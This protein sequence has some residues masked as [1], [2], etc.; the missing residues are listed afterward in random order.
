[1]AKNIAVSDEIYDIL[2]RM[3]KEKESFSDVIRRLIP[4]KTMLQDLIGRKTFSVQEWSQV[5]EAFRDQ[6][7]LDKE[8]KENLLNRIR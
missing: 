4:S 5:E 8:R 3:K 2:S 6:N 7:E 1:M